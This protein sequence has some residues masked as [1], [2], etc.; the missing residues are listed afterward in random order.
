MRPALPSTRLAAV[1][2]AAAILACLALLA[3]ADHRRDPQDWERHRLLY[4]GMIIAAVIVTIVAGVISSG[5]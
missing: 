5:T 4:G 1:W 2:F 3:I